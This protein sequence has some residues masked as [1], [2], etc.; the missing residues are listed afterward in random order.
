MSRQ[1]TAEIAANRE[2][3]SQVARVRPRDP[4]VAYAEARAYLQ[5]VKARRDAP[6]VVGSYCGNVGKAHRAG[7]W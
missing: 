3:L 4:E 1:G 5:Q 6:A 7:G 2:S